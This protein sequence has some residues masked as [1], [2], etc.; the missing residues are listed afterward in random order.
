MMLNCL[1]RARETELNDIDM[2][3]KCSLEKEVRGVNYSNK[4]YTEQY[5]TRAL[6]SAD[7]RCIPFFPQ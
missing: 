4:N 2:A 6:Q 5:H 3:V 7:E 1:L